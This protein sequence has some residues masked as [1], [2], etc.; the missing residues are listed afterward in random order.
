MTV[1]DDLTTYYKNLL[2]KQYHDKSKALATIDALCR[3]TLCDMV[4]T[5]VRDAFSIDTA[6]GDQLDLLGKYVGALRK[7]NS[8]TDL[9]DAELRFLI[10][11]KTIQNSTDNSM[12]SIDDYLFEFFGNA[13]RAV[14]N[15]DMTITYQFST[16]FTDIMTFA[17]DTDSLPRPLSVGVILYPAN[18]PNGD[19]GFSLGGVADS[20]IEGYGYTINDA[21]VVDEAQ[22]SISN[23][24]VLTTYAMIG[25]SGVW[26]ATDPGHTGT[27][28]YTAGSFTESVITLGTPLPNPNEPV[29]INYTAH[30][31]GTYLHII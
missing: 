20:Q 27:N 17:R 24:T 31:G 4:F 22:T 15:E 14:N 2:I 13:V 28:Y 25:V 29:L 6:V 30:Y 8:T 16:F 12:Y 23:S 7:P 1:I 9:E 11:M 5:E 19:F 10:K 26:L 21:P 3:Q 18:N